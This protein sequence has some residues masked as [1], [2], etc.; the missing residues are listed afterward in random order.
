MGHF[1]YHVVKHGVVGVSP[2]LGDEMNMFVPQSIEA[3]AEIMSILHSPRQIVSP[4]NN[5]PVIGLVQ[6]GITGVSLMSQGRLYTRDQMATF[7]SP[8]IGRASFTGLPEPDVKTEDGRCLWTDKQILETVIPRGVVVQKGKHTIVNG[9]VSAGGFNKGLYGPSANGL[10]HKIH[11]DIGP[12]A[13]RDFIYETQLLVNGFLDRTGFSVGCI[14][15]QA[16]PFVLETVDGQLRNAIS[17]VLAINEK[18]RQGNLPIE[19]GFTLEETAESLIMGILNKVRDD[20]GRTIS[21]LVS[22]KNNRLA[23][24]VL[25]G[26]KGNNS[27]IIQVLGF[28]GQ[29]SVQGARIKTNKYGGRAFRNT[30]FGDGNPE[31]RGFVSSSYVKGLN[32]NEF[33]CHAMGGREGVA[34]SKTVQTS[35]TGYIYKKL[36]KYLEDCVVAQDG[37][38]R[39]NSQDGFVIQFAYGDD[40]R[41][42]TKLTTSIFKRKEL[43]ALAAPHVRDLAQQILPQVLVKDGAKISLPFDID[44][45]LL[46]ASSNG[47]ATVALTFA[48]YETVVLPR[49]VR[50]MVGSG[51]PLYAAVLCNVSFERVSTLSLKQC[52][53][54]LEAVQRKIASSVI[55]V[56]EMVG[57]QAAQSICEPLTQ[58]ALNS[59]H[60]AGRLKVT[61]QSG[62][63][64]FEEILEYSQECSHTKTPSMTVLSPEGFSEEMY[65]ER[66]KRLSQLIHKSIADAIEHTSYVARVHDEMFD[67]N[68]AELKEVTPNVGA[69]VLEVREDASLCRVAAQLHKAMHEDVSNTKGVYLA[70][71]YLDCVI[72]D[73]SYR[74]VFVLCD[75][76][77][78]TFHEFLATATLSG[79]PRTGDHHVK[80][81]IM[82]VD[83]GN[84]I[85]DG[86]NLMGLK[87][88]DFGPATQEAIEADEQLFYNTVTNDVVETNRVLGIEAARSTMVRE[89]NLVLGEGSYINPRHVNLLCDAMTQSGSLVPVSRKGL[90]ALGTD[91]FSKVLF[92]S[93]MSVLT[94]V[95]KRHVE[96][97]CH[98]VSSSVALGTLVNGGTNYTSS[99][100]SV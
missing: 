73:V 9:K 38:V 72:I 3:T 92:E 100:L 88:M 91:M 54:V 52:L 31:S 80:N 64:R 50:L 57:L 84:I 22:M 65:E 19:P 70:L 68:L 60:S 61:V 21:T 55:D 67:A 26:A 58:T 77:D 76:K 30:A 69:Y 7:L 44:D 24:M 32:V 48:E 90:G 15:C 39:M 86:S 71:N 35:T 87:K 97:T 75:R 11:R 41:N 98:S 93:H 16:S 78:A 8:L 29:Q 43:A 74:R 17:E 2:T 99:V 6:D 82:D 23:R 63:P 10:I 1:C 14:D 46:R 12:T 59:F 49:L 51:N 5:A 20:A 40:R 56:G 33:F 45:E 4:Q 42:P 25:S 37:S 18:C 27:N 96:E 83:T 36:A 47:T 79:I 34:D 62:F 66:A 13:A 94:D 53:G 85:T 81:A 89:M 95:T 28:L